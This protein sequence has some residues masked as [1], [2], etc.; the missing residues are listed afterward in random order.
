MS[1]VSKDES[2]IESMPHVGYLIL[3]LLEKENRDRVTIGEIANHLRKH[4][5][6]AYRPMMFGL[7]FLHTIEAI[8]FKEPYI[9]KLNNA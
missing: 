2:L 3:K 5:V 7:I 8:D 4:E 9:Y 6:T 1:L